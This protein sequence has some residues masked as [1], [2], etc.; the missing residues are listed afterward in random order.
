M[1]RFMIITDKVFNSNISANAKL[2]YC[3]ISGLCNNTYCYASNEYL[4]DKM[5]LKSVRA[6]QLLLKELQDN[7]FIKIDYEN[8]HRQIYLVVDSENI[9][10]LDYLIEKNKNC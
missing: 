3:L 10:K 2:L 6:V 9:K 7:K 5:Q 4:R 1:N 8:N